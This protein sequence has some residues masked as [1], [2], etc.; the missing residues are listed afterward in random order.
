MEEFSFSHCSE[1]LRDQGTRLSEAGCAVEYQRVD[2]PVQSVR[3]RIEN[4]KYLGEVVV[5]RERGQA[6]ISIFDVKNG[7][8]VMENGGELSDRFNT[9]LLQFMDY[10]GT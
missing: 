2:L 4:E 9:E 1:W 7:E 5:W 10:F 3:V 6:S 8:V